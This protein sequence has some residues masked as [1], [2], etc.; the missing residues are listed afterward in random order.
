LLRRLAAGVAGLAA[1]VLPVLGLGY[2]GATRPPVV[3]QVALPLAGLPPGTRLRVLHV[4]DT[5]AGN[6]DMPRV[7]LEGIVSQAN[8]LKPDLILLT[9]DYHGGKL[10]DWPGMRL[11][12]ALAPLARLAAPLGVFASMGNHDKAKWTPYVLRQQG[13]PPL[14]VNRWVTAG[15]VTIVGVDSQIFAPDF[16]GAFAGV[17]RDRPALLMVHEPDQLLT[18]RPPPSLSVLALAGHTHG[19]QVALPILGPVG[20]VMIGGGPCIRG[21]CRVNGW[22]LFVSSGVGTSWLPLRIGVPPE[23]VL[24]TLYSTG[25]KSGTER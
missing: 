13:G 5:H 4:T 20:A 24:L 11:E 19:G 9:G 15:P 1:L 8:A 22:N 25:R 16:A 17:P 12:P 10:V 2:W 6:P 23:M 21:H 14:L 18:I 7:R 3:E